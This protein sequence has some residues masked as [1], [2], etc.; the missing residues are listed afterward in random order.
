V[1]CQTHYGHIIVK[2]LSLV[3]DLAVC[4]EESKVYPRYHPHNEGKRSGVFPEIYYLEKKMCDN[5]SNTN[6]VLR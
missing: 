3:V 6:F 5:T 1:T 2:D 4:L